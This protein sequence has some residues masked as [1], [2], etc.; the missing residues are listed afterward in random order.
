MIRFGKNLIATR[1]CRLIHP[2]STFY[3][4]DEGTL[5]KDGRL[6]VLG[7]IF[8]T[9]KKIV[10]LDLLVNE[11]DQNFIQY[12]L[13]YNRER[14]DVA[15]IHQN[16]MAVHSGF[17]GEI[18]FFHFNRLYLV[19]G[20]E[21][22]EFE[23]I[24]IQRKI[25]G[26]DSYQV[27]I[28]KFEPN[29]EELIRQEVERFSYEPIISIIVPLYNPTRSFLIEMIDSVLAQTY[30]NFELCLAEGSSRGRRSIKEILEKYRES[31]SRI[32]VKYLTK[33]SR[34]DRLGQ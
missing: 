8:S 25:E 13:Q 6:V 17:Y 16:P 2:P 18:P 1:L 20:F 33:P 22:G 5:N 9:E 24:P 7:W 30:R 28:K 11:R 34:N 21:N 32:K 15:K 23:E 14:L 3:S 4:I 26:E 10:S 31:E 19:A 29:R 27:W 12:A